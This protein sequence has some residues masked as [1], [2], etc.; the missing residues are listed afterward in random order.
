MLFWKEI[1]IFSL[2]R[3][4]ALDYDDRPEE[5]ALLAH[6]DGKIIG[7][8]TCYKCTISLDVLRDFRSLGLA[9]YLAK[10]IAKEIEKRGDVP[11]YI[12]WSDNIS[13]MRTALNAGF[14]PIGSWYC[15]EYR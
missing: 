4:S 2:R 7:L 9:S 8:A 14:V 6:K 1:V 13:S 10:E 11:V 15:T 3:R 12:T 5:F